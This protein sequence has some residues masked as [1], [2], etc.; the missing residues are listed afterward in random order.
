MKD[1]RLWKE[2]QYF[3]NHQRE[4]AKLYKGRYIVIRDEKVIGAYGSVG[5]AFHT[6]S[7]QYEPE[8]FLIQLCDE[9]PECYT[10]TMNRAVFNV[11]REEKV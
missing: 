2:F 7:K 6:T 11:V 10:K 9:G 8:T 5:E 3:L 4:L 1:D